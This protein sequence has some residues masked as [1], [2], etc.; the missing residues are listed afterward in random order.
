VKAVAR[1]TNQS[2]VN[3]KARSNSRKTLIAVL[4]APIFGLMMMYA[5]LRFLAGAMLM[6]LALME[7]AATFATVANP[8]KMRS[9]LLMVH[10][11]CC[12]TA[13]VWIALA[14]LSAAGRG[15][16][17]MILLPALSDVAAQWTG[18][19]AGMVKKAI[20]GPEARLRPIYRSIPSKSWAGAIG[21]AAVCGALVGGNLLAR[22]AGAS[23]MT[24][25][26]VQIFD[27][28]LAT[29]LPRWGGIIISLAAQGGDFLNSYTK[30][31]L[32]IKDWVVSGGDYVLLWEHG[33]IMDRF[34]AYPL[35]VAAFLLLSR[36]A[37]VLW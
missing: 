18:Q 7:Y 35:A 22:G 36:G 16:A 24:A 1:T 15:S 17:M 25:P 23:A 6:V 27:L 12:G 10:V 21:A 37:G 14:G 9:R 11:L 13:G 19:L 8:M 28:D 2:L 34:C 31:K 26:L 4:L 3:G 30:R 5:E 33:G 20:R 32:G 29:S